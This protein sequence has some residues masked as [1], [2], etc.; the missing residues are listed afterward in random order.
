M[1][2]IPKAQR[3]VIRAIAPPLTQFGVAGALVDPFLFP[4][5]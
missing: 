1:P 4:I 2:F 5:A 3:V